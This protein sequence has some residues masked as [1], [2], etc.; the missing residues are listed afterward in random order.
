MGVKPKI[1]SSST[2]AVVFDMVNHESLVAASAINNLYLALGPEK[3]Q[4]KSLKLVDIR[5]PLLQ[6]DYYLFIGI[7]K[8][9]LITGY[10]SSMGD[11]RR[12]IAKSATFITNNLQRYSTPED[13]LI[14]QATKFYITYFTSLEGTYS[15]YAEEKYADS[16]NEHAELLEAFGNIALLWAMVGLEFWRKETDPASLDVYLQMVEQCHLNYQRERGVVNMLQA[17]PHPLID[18]MAARHQAK[19]EQLKQEAANGNKHVT[20]MDLRF[21]ELRKGLLDLKPFSIN[22]ERSILV[23]ATSMDVHMVL[24]WLVITGQKWMHKS[25]GAY[26]EVVMRYNRI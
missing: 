1:F 21:G 8:A 10:Y 4:L 6:A 3:T 14:L 20:Y 9:E 13:T 5:D 26:G 22:G 19:R 2:L 12:E 15:P 18:R 17:Y 24:R 7:D 23:T 11:Q 16:A 25:S